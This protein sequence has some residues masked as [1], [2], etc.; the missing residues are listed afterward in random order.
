MSRIKNV[1]FITL[2]DEITKRE[3]LTDHAL[4][5]RVDINP[6]TI[7]RIRSRKTKLV[8]P[9]LVKRIADALAYEITFEDN[10]WVLKKINA[11][12]SHLIH[13]VH[14]SAAMRPSFRGEE[15]EHAI[16]EPGRMNRVR[17][18]AGK[19]KSR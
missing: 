8:Q 13:P 6:S 5:A 2:W 11:A 3:W 4:A 15:V 16:V 17:A 9:E 10:A 7:S 12:A 18:A 14:E 1:S 19:Y